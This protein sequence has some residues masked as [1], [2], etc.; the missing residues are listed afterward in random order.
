VTVALAG[1]GGDEL[2]A[3]YDTFVAHGPA[4]LAARLPRPALAAA[5][6]LAARL[7]SSS[8][9]MSLDFRVKQFL[10]GLDAGPSLRHQAWIGSFVPAELAR[11]LAPELS[12]LARPEVAW[13]EVLDE[14]GRA[15]AAG[16]APGSVDEALR[17]FLTR[18]LADD[19]LVKADRAS[20]AAS[21]EVRA[22]FL[23]TE[24]V[25]YA[26]RLPA[27]MKLARGRTKLVL[28]SA[29]RGLVP[30]AI[31]DRP[32]KGFG[33]PVAAWIRG[34]L[35]PMF[36]DLFS[37]ASLASAA[38]IDPAAA[39][40]LLDRHQSGAADLRKPLWTLAV[41]LLWQRRWARAPREREG[42]RTA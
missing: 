39:R 42:R 34:P 19:I 38:V 17:F 37:P 27:R 1:D 41:F 3:G 11:L 24:V 4:A 25:E 16:V 33:I 15:T 28:K 14:A 6:A 13:R 12:P 36:E 26:L 21:L 40:A 23:D 5:A 32:K 31:L 20:M 7:P 18:Y 29:L 35:R 8:R 9:N 30:G 10:R 2:F 22:P